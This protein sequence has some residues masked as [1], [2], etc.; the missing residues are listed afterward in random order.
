MKFA[1]NLPN[2][3]FSSDPRAIAELAIKAERA[4]WDGFF[5]W[6]H[7]AGKDIGNLPFHDPTVLLSI[8]AITTKKIQ[9]GATITPLPRRR[10]WKVAREFI[11]I[12][13]LS[14]GRLITAFALGNPASEFTAFGEEA[15]L[16]VRAQK[17][18]EGLAILQGLWSG[19]TFSYHGDIYQV[20]E[21]EF[22]PKPYNGAIPI[23]I[24][25]FW[26]NKKPMIRASRYDGVYPTRNWPE[27]F[28][29]D[30][31][32]KSLEYIKK[33][34]GSLDNYE[35]IVGGKTPVEADKALEIIKPYQQ[36]GA[37]C[38]S[39]DINEWRGSLEELTNR[40]EVGPPKL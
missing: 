4:G 13:H 34:R 32:E 2:F 12:D 24:G 3:G 1:V 22:M 21:V 15:D 19:K 28:S 33:Y 31:L 23:I 17:L 11:S 29:P 30:D 18:D 25:G 14:K 37:T 35:V 10:P 5:L 7:I 8:I 26:P 9:L 6:D 38:W 40:I 16:K 36:A 27:K 39:E 20:E